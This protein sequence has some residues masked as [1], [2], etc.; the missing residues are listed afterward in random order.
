MQIK[1]NLDNLT[2]LEREKQLIEKKL[3]SLSRYCQGYSLADLELTL[4][5]NISQEK[6]KILYGRARLIL[7]GKDIIVNRQGE[8]M[9][10]LINQIRKELKEDIIRSKKK[11]ESRL[12]R[13][14]KFFTKEQ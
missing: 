10:S 3:G 6:G 14:T 12:R 11:K 4:G 8:T 1:I 13:I 5:Q 2:L 7:P 9:L